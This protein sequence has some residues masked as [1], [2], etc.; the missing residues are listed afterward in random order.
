MQ[1]AKKEGRV[2]IYSF[3]FTG[4]M[5]IMLQKAFEQRYG[6]E[7]E[8]VTGRGAEFIERLKTEKRVGQLTADTTE[9][10]AIHVK[11]MKLEGITAGVAGELPALREKDKWV[12]DLLS[13]DPQDKHLIIH[14][15]STYAPHINTRL[16]KAGEE[17][18]VWR[19]LLDPK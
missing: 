14:F 1:S 19:D 9:G 12:I 5:G 13:L 6:I 2:T 17:P 3:N 16:V 18:R 4:E 15:I 7:L 11:N 8:I 10:S